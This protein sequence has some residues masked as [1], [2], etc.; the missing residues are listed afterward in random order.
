MKSTG[1][2]SLAGDSEDDEVL[3]GDLEQV[4]L[5][6]ESSKSRHLLTGVLDLLTGVFVVSLSL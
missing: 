2:P 5:L 4:V 6:G 3:S 1:D